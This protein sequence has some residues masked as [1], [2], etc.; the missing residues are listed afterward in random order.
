MLQILPA[1][2]LFNDAVT[3]IMMLHKIMKTIVR[4]YDGDTDIIEIVTGVLQRYILALCM[5]ISCRDYTKFM[6][7]K[8]YAKGCVR[9]S[10]TSAEAYLLL[11]RNHNEVP[12][13]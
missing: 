1:Y 11:H 5:F 4:S 2:D 9:L 3:A 8:D 13:V 10:N 12:V 7:E 6:T